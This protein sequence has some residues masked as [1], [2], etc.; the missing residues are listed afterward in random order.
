MG[1]RLDADDGLL[2]R[3]LARQVL[4][5]LPVADAGHGRQVVAVAAGSEAAHLFDEP[6][7]DHRV[8]PLVDAAVELLA[9]A[10][11]AD[12]RPVE[13]GRAAGLAG[14]DRLAGSPVDLQRADHAPDVAQIDAGRVRR[15]DARQ[16]IRQPLWP[17]ALGQLLQLGSQRRIGRDAGYLPAFQQKGLWERSS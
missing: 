8:D 14:G 17:L 4:A 16:L 2:Q 11:E 7:R 5:H 15:V 1:L 10:D 6:A 13:V 12:H 9:R 3:E